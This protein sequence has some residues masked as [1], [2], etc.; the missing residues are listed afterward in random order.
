[1]IKRGIQ[2]LKDKWRNRVRIKYTSKGSIVYLT[3]ETFFQ[4]YNFINYSLVL[5]K[6]VVV[7][8]H[9]EG[10]IDAKMENM[11]VKTLSP[12]QDRSDYDALIKLVWKYVDLI[13]EKQAEITVVAIHIEIVFD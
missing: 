13:T 4:Y 7:V 1:M 9:T 3:K 12:I 8:L 2:W 11:W 10:G 5:N 6:N